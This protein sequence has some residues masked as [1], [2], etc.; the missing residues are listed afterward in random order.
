MK[1]H[2]LLAFLIGTCYADNGVCNMSNGSIGKCVEPGQCK[3]PDLGNLNVYRTIQMVCQT[4]EECCDFIDKKMPIVLMT[5]ELLIMDSVIFMFWSINAGFHTH[6]TRMETS[7][8]AR[9][10]GAA[11]SSTNKYEAPNRREGARRR[12]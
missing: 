8:V 12:S 5:A 9:P 6:P 2:L 1:V 3:A 10:A 7:E 11:A 4:G